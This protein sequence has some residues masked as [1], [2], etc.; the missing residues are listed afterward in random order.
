MINR[1]YEKQKEYVIGLRREFHVKPEISWH[2]TETQKRI[3]NELK[4]MGLESEKC[5]GTGVVATIQGG[6]PGRTVA[7]RADIDALEITE[8]SDVE[9]KSSNDGVMHACG[10]DGHAAMLLGAAKALVESK[11]DLK[12]DVRLLFQPAEETLQGAKKMIEC[13]ALKDVDAIMG[14]H[15]WNN[16]PAGKVNVESGPRM[17]SGDPVV[18]DFLGKGGHGSLPNQTVDP[19]VMASSFIM[20]SNAII[21]RENF[22]W[23]PWYSQSERSD[24]EQDST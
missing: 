14:Q 21:S 10:H 3:M 6:H 1:I 22:P 17:A 12:G 13:G 19:V 2:E 20:N 11:A 9:Y 8:A 23:S 24:A 4:S 16:I 15:L 18:I 7:L 5:A